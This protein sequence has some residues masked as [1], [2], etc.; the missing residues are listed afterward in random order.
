MASEIKELLEMR[1]DECAFRGNVARGDLKLM[2]Q[3]TAYKEI[4]KKY[5]WEILEEEVAVK[6]VTSVS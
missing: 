2:L 3:F 6:S 4:L 1:R 5:V